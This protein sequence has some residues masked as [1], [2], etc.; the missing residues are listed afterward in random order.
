M[1]ALVYGICAANA[2]PAHATDDIFGSTGLDPSFCK[3][4][5]IRQTVAY[6][7]DMM[8]IDGKQDWA[9]K[10]AGKLRATLAPGER[11]SVV[12]LSPA[13]GQSDELWSG[14][15]PELSAA[16]RA[17]IAN[18]SYLFSRSPLDSLP[19]QKK[20]FMRDLD[21][22]LSAIFS[23]SKRPAGAARIDPQHPPTKN[24]IRALAFD[25]GRFSQSRITIRAIVY[26]DLAENSDLGSVFTQAGSD[27]NFGKKLGTYLRRSVFYAYGMAEDVSNSASVLEL[28]RKF[29]T[30]ALQSMNGS[31]GGLG[32]DLNVQN[33]VPLSEHAYMVDLK[34]DGQDLDGRMSLLVDADGNLV[35]SWLQ[36]TRLSI[37]G[38]T[39]I[40]RCEGATES[41]TCHL[42][43]KT[44]AGLVTQSAEEDL[45]LSGSEASGMSGQI[46]VKGALM[47]SLTAIR[48][49][50]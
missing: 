37:A 34:R 3:Q 27:Q 18:E 48:S 24:I 41:Q 9:T 38:L 47:Y 42:T 14:C 22:A 21:R 31:I 13:T 49:E 1:A 33:A 23:A 10:L 16:Q 7:D 20:Y 50:N 35:D 11:V 6:I 46:G 17:H 43:A 32:T 45:S 30:N 4:A 15:W 19:E 25:E 5:N 8:M 36:I 44:T 26:S 39:G 12:R 28:T 29:W 40:L 2:A